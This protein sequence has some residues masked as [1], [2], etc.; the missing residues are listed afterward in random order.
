MKISN[1]S[2]NWGDYSNISV[3]RTDKWA[4]KVKPQIS[5]CETF[6][7]LKSLLY[8]SYILQST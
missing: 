7:Q 5:L 4:V 2:H 6:T 1:V 8:C 3:Y